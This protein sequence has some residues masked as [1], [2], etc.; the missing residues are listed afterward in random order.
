MDTFGVP[1]DILVDILPV[2]ERVAEETRVRRLKED[3]TALTL[4]KCACGYNTELLNFSVV[5]TGKI[6]AVEN[7]CAHCVKNFS[8]MARIV[9]RNCRT[10][11]IYVSEHTD[12]KGFKFHAG[13]WYHVSICPTCYPDAKMAIPEEKMVHDFRKNGNGL[14]MAKFLDLHW[15]EW[16]RP[17][18]AEKVSGDCGRNIIDRVQGGV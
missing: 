13:K 8:N 12:T 5:N 17:A 7:I 4:G 11:V 16:T 14:S 15:G 6:D 1:S 3:A 10:P 9:C 2:V 18:P